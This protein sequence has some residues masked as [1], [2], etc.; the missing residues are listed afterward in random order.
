MLQ[1][2]FILN[3]NG[4]YVFYADTN[5]LSCGLRIYTNGT[6]YYFMFGILVKLNDH[7]I[8]RTLCGS[9]QPLQRY[10]MF[11]ENLETIIMF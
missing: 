5:V 2:I 10:F 3:K 6:V 9:D 7:L 8:K 1:K 4:T 11:F